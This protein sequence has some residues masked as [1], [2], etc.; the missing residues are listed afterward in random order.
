M[1]NATIRTISSMVGV[2]AAMVNFS[3]AGAIFILLQRWR[4]QSSWAGGFRLTPWDLILGI[5]TSKLG[6]GFAGLIFG[7]PSGFDN[8][9]RGLAGVLGT[10][11][12]LGSV[13]F[14]IG[15]WWTRRTVGSLR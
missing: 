7:L 9:V 10:W 3:A 14:P 1:D 2:I 13:L 15:F 4:P 12:I 5:I 8:L 6:S 11:L